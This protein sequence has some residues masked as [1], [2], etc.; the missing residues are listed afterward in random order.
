MAV[1][2]CIR[3]WF[4]SVSNSWEKGLGTEYLAQSKVVFF[5]FLFCHGNK[6]DRV[7][8]DLR[9]IDDQERC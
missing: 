3:D 9:Y 1:I 5:F 4:R 6:D 2:V 7:T 8:M